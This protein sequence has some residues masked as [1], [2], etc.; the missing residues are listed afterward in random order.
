MQP[1]SMDLELV[2]SQGHPSHNN[3]H[4][5]DA[6]LLGGFSEQGHDG[7]RSAP[8]ARIR[9]ESHNL[10]AALPV[11]GNSPSGSVCDDTKQELQPVLLGIGTGGIIH[12][13][14]LSTSVDPRCVLYLFSDPA[15]KQ[16]GRQIASRT[17]TGNCSCSLVAKASLVHATT[18]NVPRDLQ[19]A[20][21]VARSDYA[22]PGPQAA[23]R[24]VNTG[25]DGME[26]RFLKKILLNTRKSSTRRSYRAKWCRFCSYAAT[27][28]FQPRQ[29]SLKD[30]LL[31]LT[32]LKKSGLANVSIRVHMA[33]ISARHSGWD[34]KIVFTHPRCK[35]FL[36]G[37]NNLY[38]P[39]RPPTLKWSLS[40]VLAALT[41]SP[42]EPLAKATVKLTTLKTLFLVAITTAKCVSGLKALP[43]D[44]YTKFYPDRVV[45]RLDPDFRPKIL[46]DSHLN[47]DIVLP[48][49]SRNPS[50]HLERS[51]HSLDVRRALLFYLKATQHFLKTKHLFI[52]EQ[53]KHKGLSPSRQKLSYWLVEL[54]KLAYGL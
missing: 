37:I 3:T 45:M 25:S 11:V 52:C 35:D 49:F 41:E 51:M 40:L 50:T 5:G 9:V 24:L 4:Q 34:D 44:P 36:K 7:R 23:P 28:D 30:V 47:A 48:T 54:I 29:A 1:Q 2:Y 20:P 8:T 12:R 33:A 21:L 15:S 22:G 16:G 53:G 42:F 19:K 14:C 43:Y 46:T 26:D 27:H 18:Q 31:Y 6:K 17:Y 38:P 32:S 13:R 39:V 10:K